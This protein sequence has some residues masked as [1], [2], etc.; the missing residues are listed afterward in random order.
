MSVNSGILCR[1]QGVSRERFHRT[2]GNRAEQERGQA[3]PSEKT[4]QADSEKINIL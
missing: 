4:Y 3:T 1:G 2:E